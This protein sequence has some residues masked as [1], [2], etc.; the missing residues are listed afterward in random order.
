M[1]KT[2]ASGWKPNS[3]PSKIPIQTRSPTASTCNSF[4]RRP[5]ADAQVELFDKAPDGAVRLTLHRT[6]PQGRVALPVE[7]GHTYMVNAVALRAPDQRHARH[8]AVW[9]TLWANLTFA[10]PE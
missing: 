7:P 9:E 1:A 4:R 3:L 10:V 6:D 2:V 8:R 5:R